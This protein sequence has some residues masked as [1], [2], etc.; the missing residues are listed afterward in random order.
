MK[1]VFMVSI[2]LVLALTL[3]IGSVSAVS[4]AKPV[5]DLG[6]I[7]DRA[8]DGDNGFVVSYWGKVYG[9]WSYTITITDDDLGGAVVFEQTFLLAK[10]AKSFE[11]GS[12]SLS[13]GGPTLVDFGH[14]NTVVLSLQKKNGETI[15]TAEYQWMAPS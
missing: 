8:V 11:G 14:Y 5:K 7:L 4:A 15:A 9:A 12:K 13:P 2:A 3:V 6:I 1:M 10:N